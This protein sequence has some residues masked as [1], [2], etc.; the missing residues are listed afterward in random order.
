MSA[1]G[2]VLTSSQTEIE[3]GSGSEIDGAATWGAGAGGGGCQLVV[4]KLGGPK[5]RTATHKKGTGPVEPRHREA[6]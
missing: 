2:S 4:E 5:P 1:T 3:S 6:W